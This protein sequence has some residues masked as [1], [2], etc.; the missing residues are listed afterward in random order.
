MSRLRKAFL[1]ILLCALSFQA[2]AEIDALEVPWETIQDQ[3]ASEGKHL[4]V[5]FLGDGWSM[6]SKRMEEEILKS[7]AFTTLAADRLIYCPIRARAQPKMPARKVATLQSL[8]IHFDIKTYPTVILL[9]PDGQEVIR[10][11]YRTETPEEYTSLL[12][13]I[14][15]APASPENQAHP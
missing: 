4:F 3:A 13:S 5:A 6:A 1:T 2:R 7:E 11:G 14:L 12:E 10:H 9:A 8:V 15:P